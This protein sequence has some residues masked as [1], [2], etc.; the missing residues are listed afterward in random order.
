MGV[1]KIGTCSWNYPSWVGLVYSKK[2]SRSSGYLKEYSEKYRTVEIDSWFYKL[3]AEKEV[4]EYLNAV[5]K[6]FVFSCKV[7]NRITLTHLREYKKSFKTL[8][9]NADFLSP[10]IFKTYINSIQP[11]IPRIGLIMLEF[12]YLSRDK[13]SSLSQFISCLDEFLGT[14]DPSLPL[15]IE[16]RNKNYLQK[17]YFEFLKERNIGHVFSEKLYMP[18][19]YDV[20]ERFGD[21]LTQQSTIRLLGGDRKAIEEKTAGRWDTIVEEKKDLNLIAAMIKDLTRS[22][23]TVHVYVNNHYEG[24]AP[25]TINKIMQITEK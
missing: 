2:C 21:L 24:S 18:H 8:Y 22:G 20:Y 7:S 12:E 17:E 11:M 25:L 6:D 13:M 4:S 9:T 19:I 1:L 3:P 14:T 10:D 15:A 23:K 5:D 16:T